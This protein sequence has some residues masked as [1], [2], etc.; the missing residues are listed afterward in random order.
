MTV[1]IYCG[2]CLEILP[3]LEAGTVS[4]VI[5]DPPYE[6][7]A[8][9]EMRRTNKSIQSG[10]NDVLGFDSMDENTRQAVA[11][12]AVRLCDGWALWFCQVEASALWR[13]TMVAAGAKYRRTMVWVKPDSSPQFNGQGPA[14]GYECMS[15]SWLGSGASSWNAGGKRGVYTYNCN[16]DRFG[17]HPTEKPLRLMSALIADFTNEGDTILDPFMGGGSCGVAAVRLGRNFIGIEK[18]ENYFKIAQRRIEQ[19]E[20]QPS[21]FA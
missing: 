18:D 15:L 11:R 6:A 5:G 17:G 4:H 16:T 10:E 19:A 1:K 20:S 14:Q 2:D 8:H 9:T 12:E 21:L 3:T 7:E 13:D